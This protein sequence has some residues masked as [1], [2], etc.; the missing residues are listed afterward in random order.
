MCCSELNTVFKYP[1]LS[2]L[3]CAL[4]IMTEVVEKA[5]SFI[6]T[7][8]VKMEAVGSSRT[9][10]GTTLYQAAQSYSPESHNLNI[11]NCVNLVSHFLSHLFLPNLTG[12]DIIYCRH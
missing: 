10:A 9:Q 2:P 7:A 8:G 4:Y 1:V 5:T 11:Q 6:F 12:S 3:D